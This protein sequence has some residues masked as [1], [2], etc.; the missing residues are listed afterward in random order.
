VIPLFSVI[1]V[2]AGIVIR[3]LT[4]L[5]ISIR[6]CSHLHSDN[7]FQSNFSSFPLHLLFFRSRCKRNGLIDV[8]LIR[9]G[10]CPFASK[11]HTLWNC[12][13]ERI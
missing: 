13:L 1:C 9:D 10:Q 3:S 11:D 8:G 7:G 4:I 6:R 12:N 2:S 5:Y